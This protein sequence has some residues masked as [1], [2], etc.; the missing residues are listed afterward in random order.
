ME[1]SRRTWNPD[2]TRL[3]ALRD[4]RKTLARLGHPPEEQARLFEELRAARWRVKNGLEH[5]C[6]VALLH[7]PDQ[8]PAAREQITPADFLTPA[9]AALAAVVLGGAVEA[10]EQ[11]RGAIS[12]RPYLPD[13][14][15]FDWR[16]EAEETVLRLVERRVRWERAR[17]KRA[18]P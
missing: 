18:R 8:I 17:R 12:G 1:T 7:S 16:A 10:L 9:Y 15:M 11:A 13:G 2:P 5:R 6:L 4:G 14:E 3:H